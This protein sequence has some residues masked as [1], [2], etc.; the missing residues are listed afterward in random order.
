M[1]FSIRC[2]NHGL[3]SRLRCHRRHGRILLFF[4]SF[5]CFRDGCLF[6]QYIGH[7]RRMYA[8]QFFI[9]FHFRTNITELRIGYAPL[10][11]MLRIVD[12]LLEERDIEPLNFLG[13]DGLCSLYHDQFLFLAHAH[14]LVW[15]HELATNL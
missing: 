12:S 7:F 1:R 6:F 14:D 3:R 13:Q 8:E 15:I 2:R 11:A 9:C 4:S 10:I 5:P